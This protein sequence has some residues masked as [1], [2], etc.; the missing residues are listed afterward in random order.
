[1]KAEGGH[2]WQRAEAVDSAVRDHRPGHQLLSTRA[3]NL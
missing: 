3:A 1:M 2:D